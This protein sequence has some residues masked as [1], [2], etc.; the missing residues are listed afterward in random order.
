MT[1]FGYIPVK[2]FVVYWI[3][4][5]VVWYGS[6]LLFYAFFQATLNPMVLF[7]SQIF[8]PIFLL[9]MGWLYFRG[10]TRNDWASRFV[11]AL[12]WIGLALVFA[13]ALMQPVYGASWTSLLSK[14][15][16]IG[17]A[18]NVIGLVIG[19]YVAHRSAGVPGLSARS[20]AALP[21][22]SDQLPPGQA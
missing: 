13:A 19:G 10:V 18:M 22:S 5:F 4:S 3:I 6:S 16:A 17:Q 1:L 2:R 7:A 14:N 20:K 11:T 8:A 12:V 21:R 9:F 15:V